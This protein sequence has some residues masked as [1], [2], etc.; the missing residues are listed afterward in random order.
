L[1]FAAGFG[2]GNL[3]PLDASGISHAED[4]PRIV[5][6]EIAATAVFQTRA[7]RAAGGPADLR[8]DRVTIA[9]DTLQLQTDPTVSGIGDVAQQQRPPAVIADEDINQAVVVEVS[10]CQAPRRVWLA[11]CG[12]GIGADIAQLPG[13]LVKQKKGLLVFDLGGTSLD[14]V[15]GMPIRQ[16]QIDGA[17]VVVK[18]LSP[19]PLKY[20]VS[21]P[22]PCSREMS[23]NVS[24]FMFRYNENIS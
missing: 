11:K 7:N 19:Q 17:V 24:S 10:R 8:A 16:N 18:N 23:R 9:T 6:R 5:R 21:C 14:A 20:R 3:D 15:V 4:F 1:D 13:L 12:A 2:P 22:I